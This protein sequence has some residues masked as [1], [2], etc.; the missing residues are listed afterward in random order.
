MFYAY[1]N[2]ITLKIIWTLDDLKYADM[3]IYGF[4]KALDVL[5]LTG[6]KL[7]YHGLLSYQICSIY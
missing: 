7:E 3:L 1:Q 6:K 4:R 5:N 2:K